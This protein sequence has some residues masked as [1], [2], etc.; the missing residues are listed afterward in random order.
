MSTL[1]H[2]AVCGILGLTKSKFLSVEMICIRVMR[3]IL[4]ERFQN[5]TEYRIDHAEE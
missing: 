2:Y 3:Y 5:V 1:P 4:V